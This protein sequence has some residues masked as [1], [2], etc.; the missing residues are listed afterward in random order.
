MHKIKLIILIGQLAFSALDAQVTRRSANLGAQE[1]NPLVRPMVHSNAIYFDFI[2][3]AA[4][5]YIIGRKLEK[6]HP[7]ISKFCFSW[8]L[9]DLSSHVEGYAQTER[10]YLQWQNNYYGQTKYPL[11]IFSHSVNVRAEKI[12]FPS[13]PRPAQE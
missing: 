4:S 9:T 2:G 11:P 12:F 3:E 8:Q 10:N 6:S 7:K 13:S 5:S 1:L